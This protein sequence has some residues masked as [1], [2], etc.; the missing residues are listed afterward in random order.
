ME[1]RLKRIREHVFEFWQII[2]KMDVPEPIVEI[3][4]ANKT[5]KPFQLFPELWFD[6]IEHFKDKEY[7]QFDILENNDIDILGNIEKLS[8]YFKPG[9]IGTVIAIDVLE[10]VEKIWQVPEEVY[11]ILKDNGLFFVS[12]PLKMHIH[13]PLP[14]C[15]RLTEYGCRALFKE[16]FTFEKIYL[17]HE[18]IPLDAPPYIN[19]DGK[20]SFPYHYNIILKKI[21]DR[22]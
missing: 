6:T 1:D 19:M 9:S 16:Y 15:W 10:H 7:I 5:D 4:P 12:V 11:T 2:S 17:K 21:R 20:G 18:D 3:G 8:S 14:D 13:G 22:L